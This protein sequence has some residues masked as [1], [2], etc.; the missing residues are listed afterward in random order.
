MTS[1]NRFSIRSYTRETRSHFHFYHQLVLPLYGSIEIKVGE[2]SG[3]VSLGD[4]VIIK[5]GQRHD[6][7]AHEEASF[8][9]VDM[10]T[11]PENILCSIDEKFS[12]DS[13]LLSFVQFVEKQLNNSVNRSLEIV[14]FD[15][16]FQLLAQQTFSHKIDKRIDKVIS[17][18][19]KDL[20]QLHSNETLAK[21]ACLS[22]TQFKKVFKES[23]GTTTQ[24]YI[25]QL[26]M[27]KAK[28]LLS[29]TDTP[30][31]IVAESVGYQN[32]SAFSRKFK[33]HF[34]TSPKAF[35]R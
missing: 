29:H 20:S 7:R 17:I 11:L 28:T 18:I 27:E 31:C 25:T 4:C 1:T 23:I 22:T 33:E 32:P 12:V 34:G 10:D 13:S 30:I 15:L 35:I 2:F 6:F 21:H 19:T 16:F 3:F 14:M 8:I 24:R 9:V 5:S 26:R